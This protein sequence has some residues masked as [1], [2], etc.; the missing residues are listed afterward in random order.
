MFRGQGIRLAFA[1]LLAMTGAAE[2]NERIIYAS[3]GDTSRSPIGWVE[4][5]SENPGEC[6]GGA[7]EETEDRHGA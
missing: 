3:V 6:R 2:A 4:F 5:C 1:A 7:S